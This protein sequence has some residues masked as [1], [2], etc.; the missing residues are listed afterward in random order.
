MFQTMLD[1][2]FAS[3][4]GARWL[5]GNMV[6][7]RAALREF[8]DWLDAQRS[9]TPRAPVHPA[10]ELLRR[11]RENRQVIHHL[12]PETLEQIDAVLKTAGGG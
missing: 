11:L 8:A 7:A 12:L 5:P 4:E 1:V 9:P 10:I 6:V 3:E 2:F